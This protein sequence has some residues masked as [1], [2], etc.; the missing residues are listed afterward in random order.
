MGDGNWRREIKETARLCG[1]RGGTRMR[2]HPRRTFSF[3]LNVP[4]RVEGV[5]WHRMKTRTDEI[6]KAGPLLWAVVLILTAGGAGYWLRAQRTGEVA[7]LAARAVPSLDYLIGPE[8]F[9]RIKNTRNTL[10]GLCAQLVLQVK[11]RQF[12]ADHLIAAKGGPLWRT[13]R[14][15]L[16]AAIRDLERGMQEFEGTQQESE[17]AERLFFDLRKAGRFDRC[18]EVYLKTLYE[19]PTQPFVAR[20]AK[21]A[22]AA[23]RSAGREEEVLAGLR[24]W[25]AIPLD[26]AGKG[27]V[28]AMLA[29]G[30]PGAEPTHFHAG[31]LTAS[32]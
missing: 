23:A 1:F 10:E 30:R 18:V 20:F 2:S 7:V 32:E 24:H 5:E 6:V 15:H 26:M 21:D 13:S 12:S 14:P 17:I 28:E 25:I 3:R 11:N 22:V 16:E 29:K 9:S 31:P 4:L 19:H 8:S 27:A